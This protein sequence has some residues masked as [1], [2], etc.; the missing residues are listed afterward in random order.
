MT[1]ERMDASEKELLIRLDDRSKRIESRL[2]SLKQELR[3]DFARQTAVL[4]L[5]ERVSKIED[6]AEDLPMLRKVVFGGVAVVLL[7][8]AG[9]LVAMVVR[10]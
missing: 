7:A 5:R 10:G 6:R 8:V 9:A 3:Q 4:D 1:D 2:D